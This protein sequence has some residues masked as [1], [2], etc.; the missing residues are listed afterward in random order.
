[1]SG[2]VYAVIGL[3][4]LVGVIFGVRKLIQTYLR[5]KGRMLVTCPETQA[6]AGVT[7]AAGRAAWTGM[8]GEARL[9]LQSC[10]RWPERQA[11]GQQC[12]AQIEAAPENCLVRRILT[13][14]FRDKRC[15]YCGRPIGEVHWHDR[16]P[17][18]I[19]PDRKTVAWQELPVEHLPEML[20][21]YLPVCWDCHIAETFRRE[22]P[23]LVT[24]RPS[25]GVGGRAR[26]E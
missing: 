20:K 17:T 3:L 12:L 10:T 13:D 26:M 11:C 6:P 16:K 25:P 15:A 19:G 5:Y 24:D 2:I 14:W 1:M 8:G 18:I 22:H 21:N 4:V 9:R 7:V 23:E